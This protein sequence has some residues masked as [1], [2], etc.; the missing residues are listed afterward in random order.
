M[1]NLDCK[2]CTLCEN[3]TKVVNGVG[4]AS[5]KIMIVGEAPGPEEDEQGVPFVGAAGRYLNQ[6]LAKVGIA[7]EEIFLTNVTR[8]FP[9]EGKAF[10]APRWPEMM[11]CI[12]YLD[13][14]VTQVKPN[15]IVPVGNIA[16][17]AIMG[18]K[19]LSITKCRGSELWSERFNCKVIPTFHPSA[20]MRTP[21]KEQIVIHDYEK[22]KKASESKELTKIEE[23]TYVIIDSLEMFDDFVKRILQS[24]TFS[25]DIETNGL[26]WINSDM[27]CVSFSW[28]EKTACLL[29]L[30]KY[31]P[32][33]EQRTEIKKKTVQKTKNGKRIKTVE[34][35]PV[36]S[37]VIIDEYTPV[38]GDKQ[39]YVWEKLK[40][41]FKSPIPKIAHNGKFDAKFF[42][43]KG[44]E[45]ENLEFDTMLAHHLLDENAE[46]MHGLKD[47]AKLYT[48]MGDYARPIEDWFM[49]HNIPEAKRN[50]AHIPEATLYKY[51]CMDADC[52]F[53]LYKV[54]LPALVKD[55]LLDFFYKLILP[56]NRN[57]LRAEF[58]GVKI[59]KSYLQQ[60]KKELEG[61][62]QKFEKDMITLVG[63]GINFNSPKQL[64]TLLYKTLKLPIVKKTKKGAL[65][66]DAEVL[67]TLA[68]KHKFP[69]TLLLYRKLQKLYSTYILGIE[70]RLDAQ[71]RVHTSFLI[72]GTN[73]GRL[74][75]KDPNL[76]NIPSVEKDARIKNLFIA[77]DGYVFLE[78]DYAQAEFRFWANYSQDPNMLEDLRK[79]LD[80]HRQTASNVFV[81]TPDEVTKEQR[82]K[83]KRIVYGLMY[84]RGARNL[85]LDTNC[86]EDEAQKV[87]SYF[88]SRYPI[89]KRWLYQAVST[90]QETGQIRSCFG[91]LRRLPGIY[92]PDNEIRSHA[93]RQSMNSP[94][95]S[96]A[97]DL[98][99]NAA[100]RILAKFE[101]VGVKGKLRILVH[102]SIL[103]EVPKDDLDKSLRIV[104]EEM[105]RELPMINVPMVAELKVGTRWGD[106]KEV[107]V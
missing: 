53:R 17:R 51:A 58:D 44:I 35:I 31:T 46:G 18:N 68:T 7:R 87:I 20:V 83:A 29:P 106:L 64:S 56:L 88:F 69:N 107:T 59:D 71:G 93:E 13:E 12:S 11:A 82:Q 60:V 57:L 8:C 41:I 102:D 27:L 38:W 67:E 79:G 90:V 95:Q 37:T 48:E 19:K 6:M 91:R 40:E 103:L 2:K 3:R 97:S 50:Y 32:R 23:G 104:K 85:A 47:C 75:S 21:T 15:V 45:I 99:C 14:E 49:Q 76:Q 86:S 16:L 4:P 1:D 26:D 33:E 9:K 43:K 81:I 72:I 5:A 34:E 22:I 52:T 73:T 77:E 42:M 61:E 105:E 39:Q 54:F 80:I 100:N 92:H 98:N 24:E 70:V 28:K 66:V 78:A 94:I 55:G 89:A 101:E 25:F 74:S 84:G 30:L 63:S 10:R 62:I 96:A 36:T 65:S